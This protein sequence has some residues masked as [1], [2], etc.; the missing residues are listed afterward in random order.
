MEVLHRR[1]TLSSLQIFNLV[2]V[3]HPLLIHLDDYTEPS[4]VDDKDEWKPTTEKS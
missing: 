3:A 2:G 1:L 4:F